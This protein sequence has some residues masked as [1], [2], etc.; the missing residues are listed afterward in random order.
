MNGRA[1]DY[2]LGRFLSVDPIIQFPTNSQ[3]LNPYS[4][5][6]NNPLSGTDPTGYVA[7]D[8]GAHKSCLEDGVNTITKDGKTIATVIV[9]NKGDELTFSGGG[10][11]VSGVIGKSGNGASFLASL[12]KDTS[13]IGG[14]ASRVN[15]SFDAR[16]AT[17]A[18]NDVSPARVSPLAGTLQIV[19]GGPA[20]GFGTYSNGTF[21]FG[22][23]FSADLGYH[24]V[25]FFFGGPSNAPGDDSIESWGGVPFPQAKA[26]AGLSAAGVLAVAAI[27]GQIHHI[28]TNKALK[29]GFTA[30]FEKIFK[31]AGMNLQDEA[32]KVFLTGHAGR[33]SAEYHRYVLERLRQ[34]TDGL[35]GSQAQGALRVTLDELR[36]ELLR[37][38]DLVRGA[39]L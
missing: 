27:R 20:S 22:D 14:I 3:S 5:I 34:A 32:N 26:A 17:L 28:A 4:Y 12:K 38:P 16:G 37:N 35:E 36:Q 11:S 23:S 31:R 24:A 15:G 19:D 13:S 39:G 1:Y 18:A 10:A 29:S 7:C 6:L 21:R 25:D 33:H 30:E 2:Q 9:G 8:V